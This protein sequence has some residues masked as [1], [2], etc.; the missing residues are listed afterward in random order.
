MVDLSRVF[1][2]S[3]IL[4]FGFVSGFVLVPGWIYLDQYLEPFGNR[5]CNF[6]VSDCV[7]FVLFSL[8]LVSIEGQLGVNWDSSF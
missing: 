5:V 3:S 7:L 4:R 8:R 6:V 2:V 1:F